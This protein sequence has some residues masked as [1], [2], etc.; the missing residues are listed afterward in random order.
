MTYTTRASS[1]S[2]FPELVRAH[3]G[4]PAEL[5]REV[6]LSTAVLHDPDLHVPYRALCTLYARAAEVCDDEHFGLRL[7]GG[8]G[9]TLI[10]ALASLVCLQPTLEEALSVLLKNLGFHAQGMR[11]TPRQ[12]ADSFSLTLRLAFAAEV[13]DRQ[14]MAKSL[15]TL[16][17]S[18]AQLQ[19]EPIRPDLVCFTGAAP[20][21]VGPCLAYFGCP[22]Q[23][24]GAVAQT[25]ATCRLA[26][27]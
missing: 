4:N 24:E 7:G 6:G 23:F 17:L 22:V 13:D 16:A 12:T 15:A 9:L 5:L 27:L 10:G 26:S 18:I 1:L 14:M 3:G 19:A 8:Q 11:I 2:G 25:P 21:D 20:R